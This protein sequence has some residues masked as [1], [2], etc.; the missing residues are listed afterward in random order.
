MRLRQVALVAGELA[1]VRSALMALFGLTSDFRDPG[2]S[3][4]GLENSVMVIG[5]KFLEVVAPVEPGTT[6]QRQL[7]K[8]GGDGGYMVLLQIHDFEKYRDRTE[9]LGVRKV[10]QTDQP[11]TRAFHLHPRDIGG[12]I[13]SLD[14]MGRWDDWTWGGPDW[15]ERRAG[16]ASDILAVELRAAQPDVMAARW[17]EILDQD[18]VSAGE[19]YSIRLPDEGEI[20]FRPALAGETEGVCGLTL[21]VSDQTALEAAAAR[22][23]LNLQGNRL[24]AGGVEMTFI[25]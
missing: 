14:W 17:A 23:G 19:R 5:D 16:N 6:A 9:A 1:P 20:S 8:Q 18:V 13:V 25:S 21:K 7:D 2:V 24:I 12:A 4:F 3:E 10:W 11:G 15:R 22:L